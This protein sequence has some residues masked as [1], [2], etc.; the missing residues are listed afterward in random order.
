MAGCVSS[1]LCLHGVERDNL[2]GYSEQGHS[3]PRDMS[4]QEMCLFLSVI[5]QM[6]N[7]QSD[8]LRDCW[9]TVQFFI[10]FYGIH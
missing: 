9:L 7:N 10:V 6:E 2:L 3:L 1:C 4:I 5:L 8:V